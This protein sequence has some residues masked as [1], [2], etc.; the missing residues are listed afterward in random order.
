M[1]SLAIHPASTTHSAVVS[2]LPKEQGAAAT[3]TRQE[4]Q[5]CLHD[6]GHNTP[7]RSANQE[8]MPTRMVRRQVGG[9]SKRTGLASAGR[10]SA[11]AGCCVEKPR[12]SIVFTGRRYGIQHSA[13]RDWQMSTPQ[14]RSAYSRTAR[15]LEK[16]AMPA[17]LRMARAVHNVGSAQVRSTSSCAAMYAE[18]SASTM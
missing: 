12:K 10:S 7:L 5:L 8:A 6:G 9:A 2:T 15:S 11:C 18:K 3:R 13:G 16:R 17:T 14:M 1:R 4:S